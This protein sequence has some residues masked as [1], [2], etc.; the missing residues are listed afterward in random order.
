[1]KAFTTILVAAFG[2]TGCLAT[3]PTT[4]PTTAFVLNVTLSVD[5]ETAT[6][7]FSAHD[8]LSAC[9]MEGLKLKPKADA[10]SIK[11][12]SLTFECKAVNYQVSTKQPRTRTVYVPSSGGSGNSSGVS[13]SEYE[14]DKM[15]REQEQFMR[16]AQDQA[17]RTC[18]FAHGAGSMLCSIY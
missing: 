9:Q 17:R 15:Q 2:L 4:T 6:Q 7:S 14:W 16:D 13:R 8:T 10:E 11:Y 5:D 12:D 18:E 1:M 3:A